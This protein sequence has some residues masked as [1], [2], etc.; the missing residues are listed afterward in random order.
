M[1]SREMRKSFPRL[2]ISVLCS[3]PYCSGES[4]FGTS[5]TKR[6]RAGR[7]K[8]R[9][10][11]ALAS[12]TDFSLSLHGSSSTIFVYIYSGKKEGICVL[13]K[14]HFTIEFLSLDDFSFFN[15]NYFHFNKPV[16]L[17]SP[18]TNIVSVE[19][20]P[21]GWLLSMCMRPIADSSFV[22]LKFHSITRCKVVEESSHPDPPFR[23]IEKK[24]RKKSIAMSHEFEIA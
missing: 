23:G 24:E 3:S 1:N 6:Q 14:K 12:A 8:R 13:V 16:T 18:P 10:L 2:L 19:R 5:K 21:I 7:G 9:K 17:E 15:L 20:I 11:S 22:S 4:T